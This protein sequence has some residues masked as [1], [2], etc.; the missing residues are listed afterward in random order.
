M[1]MELKQLSRD[2]KIGFEKDMSLQMVRESQNKVIYSKIL[3][4]DVKEH[5]LQE[6]Y[7]SLWESN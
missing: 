6:I 4:P 7:S 1:S 2:T 3:Q 5:E